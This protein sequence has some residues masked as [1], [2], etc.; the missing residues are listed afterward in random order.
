MKYQ[1]ATKTDL[2]AMSQLWN[3]VVTEEYFL[4]PMS[5]NEF[6]EK[7]LTNPDFDYEA[8]TVVYDAETLIAFSIGYLRKAYI[9]NPDVAGIV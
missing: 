8:V 1:Q 2:M 9:H 4:K 7:L 3:E 6:E 5:Y